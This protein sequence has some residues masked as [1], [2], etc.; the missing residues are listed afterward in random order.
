MCSGAT[1]GGGG[2]AV[3]G[4]A[5]AYVESLRQLLALYRH[6]PGLPREEWREEMAVFVDNVNPTS[7]ERLIARLPDA[8][9]L[10]SPE[11]YGSPGY[12][13]AAELVAAARKTKAEAAGASSLKAAHT[14][15]VKA[16]AAAASPAKKSPAKASKPRSIHTMCIPQSLL[17]DVAAVEES[18]EVAG[19]GEEVN[20]TSAS[21]HSS[22]EEVVASLVE[23]VLRAVVAG[24]GVT[25]A[26]VTGASILDIFQ[27]APQPP[28]TTG[29][30][31]EPSNHEALAET[32]ARVVA[33]LVSKA[34]Q[35]AVE[36]AQAQATSRD[37]EGIV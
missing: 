21:H 30:P 24:A 28:A 15:P 11:G 31:A 37:A 35:L 8:I 22:D 4:N 3:G 20:E 16:A 14:T 33:E 19:T 36:Q 1:P 23:R 26:E 27:S 34:L 5:L 7:F 29:T 6:Y 12:V 32:E 2:A 10:H 18:R 25:P 9:A 17:V 13:S